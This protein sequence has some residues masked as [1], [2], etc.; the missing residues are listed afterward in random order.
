[1]YPMYPEQWPQSQNQGY[2]AIMLETLE[3]QV[4]LPP[5]R[6]RERENTKNKT[7]HEKPQHHEAPLQKPGMSEGTNIPK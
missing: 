5:K 2:M 4:A 7:P 3:V 1:M 6:E